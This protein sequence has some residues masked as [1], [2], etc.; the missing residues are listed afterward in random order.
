[1]CAPGMD[2]GGLLGNE[3]WPLTDRKSANEVRNNEVENFF[4]HLVTS[5]DSYIPMYTN[6]IGQI[7]NFLII[8]SPKSLYFFLFFFV[9]KFCHSP[10]L[11]S[12]TYIKT[13]SNY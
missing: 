12:G 4:F 5:C 3:H 1:M 7:S 13:P 9:W 6:V 8:L 10:I 2:A 11:Y